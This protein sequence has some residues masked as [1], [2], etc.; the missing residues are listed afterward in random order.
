MAVAL[1]VL[2]AVFTG[3][4][5]AAQAEAAEPGWCELF[6]NWPGCP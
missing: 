4:T 3:F 1:V 2:V 5:P 6:P